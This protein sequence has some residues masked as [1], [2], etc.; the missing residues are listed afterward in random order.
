MSSLGSCLRILFIVGISIP[1]FSCCHLDNEC[2]N[3]TSPTVISL[4]ATDPRVTACGPAPCQSPTGGSFQFVARFSITVG[5][6]VG[7]TVDSITV[8]SPRASDQVSLTYGADA[9]LQ[10]AGRNHL[11]A[12]ETLDVPIEIAYGT[13][14]SVIAHPWSLFFEVQFID[15]RGNRTPW[16]VEVAC[17]DSLC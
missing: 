11:Q 14:G 2:V 8:R 17:H 10:R 7:G 3:Y 4:S 9:I 15:D 1:S 13:V 12:G 6:I 16:P 5:A